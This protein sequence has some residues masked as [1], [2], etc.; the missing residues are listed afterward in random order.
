[1]PSIKSASLSKF[2]L[3]TTLPLR[4]IRAVFVFVSA[5]MRSVCHTFLE[6]ERSAPSFVYISVKSS[7]TVITSVSWL[8][9]LTERVEPFFERRYFISKPTFP[10]ALS[11]K[12]LMFVTEPLPAFT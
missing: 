4:R 11:K 1:M 5:S 9:R 2:T 7:D 3:V 6:C 10:T 8:R 12:R